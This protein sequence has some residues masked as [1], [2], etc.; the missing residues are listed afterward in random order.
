MAEPDAV[1]ELRGV[2]KKFP[3]HV[4]VD[5]VSF[6]VPRGELFALL[7]PSGCGKTTTLRMVAGFEQPTSGEIWLNGRRI[8]HLRPYQR[9]VTTVFQSYALFPH[10][11]V[12]SNVEFG[13]RRHSIRETAGRVRKVLELVQLTGK[14]SR[15]PAQL[16]GGEKQR[17]ALARALVLEP[18]LLLLDEPLS[19]L[20]PRLRKQ[21]R[22]ELK[23]LQK[24]IGITFL[25]VTHDQEEALSLSDQIAVVNRGRLE[26]VGTPREIYLKP[27]TRFVAG[28]LG[29]V[30]WINGVGVRPELTRATKDPPQ[31]DLKWARGVVER[32]TFLGNVVQLEARLES[33]ETAVAELPPGAEFRPGDRIHVCWNAADELPLVEDR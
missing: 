4:A 9:N 27:R 12:Q 18:D 11:T 3:T 8:E 14:E 20:D 6:R 23:Q 5:D 1:L 10:L 31:P 28:F 15:Y 13:L 22:A 26:Q 29:A 33:G 30:N 17:V 19:A 16:S 25:F 21:V 7:G 32:T 2:T 24:R